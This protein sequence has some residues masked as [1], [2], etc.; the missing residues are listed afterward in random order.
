MKV[1]VRLFAAAKQIVGSESVQIDVPEPPTIAGLKSAIEK[2][3][4]EL[5]GL[6]RHELFH[7]AAAGRGLSREHEEEIALTYN[8]ARPRRTGM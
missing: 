3:I 4:P 2:Q 7:V 8:G 5:A 6:L 1:N